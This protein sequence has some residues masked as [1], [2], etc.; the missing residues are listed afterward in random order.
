MIIYAVYIVKKDGVTLL[1][2]HFQSEEEL[3]NNLLL[4][5]LL[6]AI[7]TFS[8]ETLGDEM[9]TIESEGLAYHI[10]SFGLYLIA[11]ITDLNKEPD[12]LIQEL[13]LRFMRMYGEDVLENPSRI[14]KFYP[15]KTII[16]EILGKSYDETNSLKPSK[17]LNTKEIFELSGDLKPVA[18]AM[19]SLGEASIA[20]IAEESNLKEDE[21]E[22]RL[23]VLQ[24]EGF[25]GKKERE[26]KIF[27]FVQTIN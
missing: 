9:K 16:R 24:K 21:T 3:P 17:L 22:A 10:R 6:G 2:E 23:M 25:V 27:Y 19:L 11:L 18:L 14:D 4:G 20:E 8:K 1:S 12:N 26:N 15:F 5:G 7:Q 13:G